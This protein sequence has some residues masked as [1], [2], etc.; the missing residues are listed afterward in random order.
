VNGSCVCVICF[1]DQGPESG[2]WPMHA[3]WPTIPNTIY[4][5]LSISNIPRHYEAHKAA[6]SKSSS[7]SS[8]SSV[9]ATKRILW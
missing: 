1:L 2:E 4:F 3:T 5:A 6:K 7:S 8:S 9:S